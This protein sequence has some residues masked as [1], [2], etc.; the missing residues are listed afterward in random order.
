MTVGQR[1]LLV[2]LALTVVGVS[3]LV[4]QME[5]GLS[6][7]KHLLSQ[8]KI[9]WTCERL[10]PIAV[11]ARVLAGRVLTDHNQG[12]SLWWH[13]TYAAYTLYYRLRA[14]E[15]DLVENYLKTPSSREKNCH[16]I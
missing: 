9:V 11:L 2:V 6:D 12:Q 10:P 15:S 1:S 7:R 4:V 3:Y 5:N 16:R 14:P 13:P 8:S